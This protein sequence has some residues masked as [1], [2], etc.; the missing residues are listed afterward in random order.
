MAALGVARNLTMFADGVLDVRGWD[1]RRDGAV[2]RTE[3]GRPATPRN[4]ADVESRRRPDAVGSLPL[5]TADLADRIYTCA[6]SDVL[7]GESGLE[8]D[9]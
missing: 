9:P 2:R 4:A 6:L 8:R 3:Q 5:P 7:F 1:F